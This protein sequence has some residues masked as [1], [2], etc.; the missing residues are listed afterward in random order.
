MGRGQ[1][2]VPL[3]DPWISQLCTCDDAVNGVE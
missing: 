1:G 3:L 2:A